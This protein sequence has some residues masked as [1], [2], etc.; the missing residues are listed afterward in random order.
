MHFH[1]FAH[2]SNIIG[3]RAGP[4]RGELTE[5]ISGFDIHQRKPNYA[6]ALH[7]N[8]SGFGW[9]IGRSLNPSSL[10]LC[11]AEE[12]YVSVQCC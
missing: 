9:S 8:E 1:K 3:P 6:A 5:F 10:F 12:M 7:A 11:D 2:I 4:P